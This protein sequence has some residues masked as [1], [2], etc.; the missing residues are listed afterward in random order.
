MK[1]SRRELLAIGSAIAMAWFYTWGAFAAD[2]ESR[3]LTTYIPQ[4]FLE[5]AVRTENWTEITLNV[6]G[7]VRKDDIVRIWAGGLIDRGNG[8]LP[9]IAVNGPNGAPLPPTELPTFALSSNAEH[10][11]A[12]LFKTEAGGPVK[13]L[14]PGKPLEIKL[15]KDKEKVWIGFNDEKGRYHDNHLGKGK[16]HELDPLWVRIEVV[17]IT[18]D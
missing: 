4:D 5:T 16:R 9:G 17:R 8:E 7:A 10:A 15:T 12:L 1:P 6:K 18:V 2:V 11:Y 14:T 3:Q 13:C